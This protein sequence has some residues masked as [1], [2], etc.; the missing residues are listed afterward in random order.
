ME[1]GS[2]AIC[3]AEWVSAVLGVTAADVGAEHSATASKFQVSIGQ[4]CWVTFPAE[5]TSTE[6]EI[7]EGNR[8]VGHLVQGD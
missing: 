6:G 3:D 8:Q 7:D 2:A 5:V 4:F 1:S